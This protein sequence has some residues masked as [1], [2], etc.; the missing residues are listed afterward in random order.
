MKDK[1]WEKK[2]RAKTNKKKKENREGREKKV[3]HRVKST[4]KSQEHD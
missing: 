1:A 2:E 3:M 4:A